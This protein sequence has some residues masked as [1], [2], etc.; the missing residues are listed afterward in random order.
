MDVAVP[1]ADSYATAFGYYAIAIEIESSQLWRAE[2]GVLASHL[3]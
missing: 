2:W 1:L 3:D